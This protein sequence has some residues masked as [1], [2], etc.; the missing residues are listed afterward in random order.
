MNETVFL[1][2]PFQHIVRLYWGKQPMK[3]WNEG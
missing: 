2:C 3:W 1:L